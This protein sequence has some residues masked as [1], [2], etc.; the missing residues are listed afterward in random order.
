M[1][2][3]GL[4]GGCS[5]PSRSPTWVNW[6]STT[7]FGKR[8]PQWLIFWFFF[9]KWRL[10]VHV[11]PEQVFK[12]ISVLNRFTQ[13][14]HSKVKYEIIFFRRRCPS[15]R[16]R[17]CSNSLIHETRTTV[18]HISKQREIRRTA[19]CFWRTSRCFATWWN[20]V[21]S[22]WY[23]FSMRTKTKEK[24]EKWKSLKCMLIY[25]FIYAN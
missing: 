9:L 17:H 21:L 14:R 19:E 3:I 4:W 6:P 13:L 24:A 10:S 23:I 12:P 1:K 11:K 20:T 15:L 2:T 25:L 22:I 8:E 18:D 7:C 5:T 16:G